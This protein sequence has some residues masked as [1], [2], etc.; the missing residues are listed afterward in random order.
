MQTLQIPAPPKITC[1]LIT[2][3]NAFGTFPAAGW[4]V[5][6]GGWK[7]LVEGPWEPC[8]TCGKRGWDGDRRGAQAPP[9]RCPWAAASPCLTQLLGTSAPSREEQKVFDSWRKCLLGALRPRWWRAWEGWEQLRTKGLLAPWGKEKS[10]CW[11]LESS[12]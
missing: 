6:R 2:I 11:T 10:H 9:A 4:A 3:V 7:E 8:G 1:T 5:G 12:Y